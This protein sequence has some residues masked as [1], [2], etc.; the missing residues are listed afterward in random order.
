MAENATIRVSG[1]SGSSEIT[2]EYAEDKTLADVLAE[3]GIDPSLN[4]KV[5]GESVDPS[6]V[7]VSNGDQ[8][9]TT[10]PNVKLG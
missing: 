8:V 4:V 6:D 7:V 3:A 10:P 9:V 1:L 5:N 2:V